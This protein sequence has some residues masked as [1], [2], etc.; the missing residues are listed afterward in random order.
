M[1]FLGKKD[2]I[3]VKIGSYNDVNKYQKDIIKDFCEQ[4]SENIGN[5][6]ID[7]LTPNFSTSNEK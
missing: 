6:L 3:C 1:D 4:I 7:I 2:L 5:E